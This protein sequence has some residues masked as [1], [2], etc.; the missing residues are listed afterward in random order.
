MFKKLYFLMQ[1]MA[2]IGFEVQS[3][4]EG[5]KILIEQIHPVVILGGGV[6]ALTSATYLARGGITPLVITGPEI[7]GAI[8][9]SH[10][11]QNWPGEFDI[12]GVELSEKIRRQAELNGAKF[13][14]EKVVEVDFS[15]RPFKIVTESLYEAPIKRRTL[16]SQ[17]CIIAL[18]STPNFLNIPGESD[19]WLRGVYNCA[20]CDGAFYKDKTVA[21]VGGGDSALTEVHYLSS[22][23]K[24]V[25]VIIRKSEFRSVEQARVQEVLRR[26]NVEIL[27]ESDVIEIKGD[28]EKLT[29][30]VV[31]NR[32]T[33]KTVKRP[34]DALFLAI[35]SKPNTELFRHQLELDPNGYIVLKDRQETSVHGVYA[36]GDIVM[37]PP[38][39][40][41]AVAAAGDA[42]KAAL[43]A[44][45]E[46]GA[47][48]QEKVVEKFAEAFPPSVVEIHSFEELQHH[49]AEG[50]VV[51]DFYS[52]YCPPCRAFAPTYETWAKQ[53]GDRV[54]FAKVNV[55]EAGNLAAQYQVQ[56]IPTLLIF[57][58][59]GNVLHRG[60]GSMEIA[61]L[62]PRLESIYEVQSNGKGR[63]AH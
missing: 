13:L 9:Q 45:R 47:L 59:E 60:R 34:M 18:G 56:A 6:A 61:A 7:G 52:D 36:A 54:T 58:R 11:I 51:V 12:T 15:R 32:K 42:A 2:F 3:Y 33:G 63:C 19:Y 43:Q 31:R 57:D 29:Q 26:S 28:E 20:V 38:E 14:E 10:S 21:V 22:I 62:R 27:R 17:T 49:W 4:A 39:F 24:K 23:A 46:L 55:S 44:H 50:P 16:R 8:I 35:G 37:A 5:E 30:L 53:W 41:Q 48:T 1:C 25:Y 40:K